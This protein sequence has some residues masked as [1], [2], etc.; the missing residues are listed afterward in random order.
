MAEDH[1]AQRAGEEARTECAEGHQRAGQ[2]VHGW[3][4]HLRKD[5]RG[6]DSVDHEIVELQRGAHA[7][8]EECPQ[9]GV[10]TRHSLS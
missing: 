1:A 3:K 4:E 6:G 7:R 10:R 9:C 5:Q 2:R 8:Y